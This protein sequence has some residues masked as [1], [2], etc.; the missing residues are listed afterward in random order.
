QELARALVTEL[1]PYDV[2]LTPGLA[3][4]PPAVGALDADG[5]DPLATFAAADRFSPFT[6]WAN[7]TGLPA[8]M[9]P[10]AHGDDGL[11]TGVQLIGRPAREDVLLSLGAQLERAR[12]WDW[13]TPPD[14]RGGGR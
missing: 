10:L 4:R 6:A 14:P 3:Q 13:R 9:L 5:D 12:P 7:A 2:V 11:P 1:D 8:L